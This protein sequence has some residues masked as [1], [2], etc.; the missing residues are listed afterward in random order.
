MKISY[1]KCRIFSRISYKKLTFSLGKIKDV[2][3]P[4]K[5]QNLNFSEPSKIWDQTAH[6]YGFLTLEKKFCRKFVA[7]IPGGILTL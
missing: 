3:P 6:T 7:E 2:E 4:K 5:V 1:E